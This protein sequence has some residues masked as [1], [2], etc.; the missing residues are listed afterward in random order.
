MSQDA[1][2]LL[3]PQLPVLRAYIY[4]RGGRVMAS[5]DRTG[6]PPPPTLAD[7][8]MGAARL[9]GGRMVLAR[10]IKLQGEGVG[11]L[12]VEGSQDDLRKRLWGGGAIIA[13]ISTFT[14]LLAFAM[15]WPL[16]R[17][18]SPPCRISRTGS[19]PV[20]RMSWAACW[21]ISM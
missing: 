19:A 20:A 13:T 2:D 18:A 16:R 17:T 3:K 5:L 11:Y 15:S 9:V 10:E 1:L 4:D 8:P 7:L 12:Y 6:G 14:F 21:M